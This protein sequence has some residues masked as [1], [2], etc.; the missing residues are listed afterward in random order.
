MNTATQAG[1]DGRGHR[2]GKPAIGVAADRL[3]R[4]A[5]ARVI[6]RGIGHGHP[7]LVAYH[8]GTAIEE[9]AVP[10]AVGVIPVEL[11]HDQTDNFPLDALAD[12]ARACG[13]PGLL[14]HRGGEPIDYERTT[15]RHHR[16]G[17]LTHVVVESSSTDPGI[18]TMVA[19][20]AYNEA[21]TIGSVVEAAADYV[22]TVIV[23][24]DGSTDDTVA[25]A[26]QA[27]ATVIE[28][29]ENRGYGAALKTAFRVAAEHE[30]TQLVV[31][32]GDGQHDPHDIPKLLTAH[33]DGDAEIVVGSRFTDGT[34]TAM[35]IYRRMGLWVIN[36]LTNLSLGVVRRESWVRDTQ[37]GFRVYGGSAIATLAADNTMGD[38]MDASTDILYHAHHHDHEIAEVGVEINYDV[39]DGSSHHPLIHGFVLLRN[40]LRTIERERP[41]TLIGLPGLLLV[42]AGLIAAYWSFTGVLATGTVP[43]IPAILASL[44]LLNGVFACFTALVLHSINTHLYPLERRRRGG[45]NDV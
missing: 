33:R 6:L 40:I 42:L 37:S 18:E 19:I 31:I 3:E 9:L 17:Y 38:H 1:R 25:R 45:R 7:V 22:D 16:N 35:P 4:D 24:D 39:D 23:I 12:T 20:P 29:A 28:H 14:Y 27:G 26:R 11:G 30:A 13:F 43:I 10:D 41:I 34:K 2:S 8:D 32:D 44:F 21:S 5:L 15:A 36:S